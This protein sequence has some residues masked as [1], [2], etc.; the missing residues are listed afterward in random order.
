MCRW[1][2]LAL[3][4]L[5][6]GCG[7]PPIPYDRAAGAPVATVGFLTP[8]MSDRPTVCVWG[9]PG[10]M[11]GLVGAIAEA[12]VLSAREARLVEALASRQFAARPLFI[13]RVSAAI[14][15]Q[16]YRVVPVAVER[17][18]RDFLESYGGLPAGPDAWLDCFF[19]EW[20][21]LAAGVGD[22]TP[23]RPYAN[24]TCRLVRAAD[25]TVLMRDRV[26]Y[27][28]PLG[29]P[30]PNPVITIPPDPQYSFV[31]SDQLVADP[32]RAVQGIDAAFRAAAEAFGTVLK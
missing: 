26:I 30:P 24:V 5:P 28:W 7:A 14:G 25:G 17:T 4:L 31:T 9:G 2:V 21:Y 13:E 8:S 19:V 32:E 11:F 6:V 27:N 15:A 10:Q 23:Y 29:R 18:K 16:G 22:S 12:A 20:G 3:L 1:A